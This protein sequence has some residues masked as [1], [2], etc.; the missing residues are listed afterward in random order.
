MVT[1]SLLVIIEAFDLSRNTSKDSIYVTFNDEN[2][3]NEEF[4]YIFSSYFKKELEDTINF[5]INLNKPVLNKDLNY[6]F[7]LDTIKIPDSL[8]FLSYLKS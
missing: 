1:D 4:N 6:R 5:S 3:Y 7:V 8:Y 2:E